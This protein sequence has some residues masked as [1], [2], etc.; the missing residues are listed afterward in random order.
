MQRYPLSQNELKLFFTVISL[1]PQIDFDKNEMK[2]CQ[3]V[4]E[5]LDYIFKTETLIRPYNSTEKE[6][7]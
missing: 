3:N 4:R 6:K 5:G 1:P 2:S 7:Q